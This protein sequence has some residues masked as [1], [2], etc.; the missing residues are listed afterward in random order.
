MRH[1]LEE[2]LGV[3]LLHQ[4]GGRAAHQQRRD[5]DAAGRPRPAS[6]RPRS[7]PGADPAAAFE[8]SRVPVPAPAAVGMQ[9]QVLLQPLVRARPRPVRQIGGDRVGGLRDRAEAFA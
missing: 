3:L 6:A 5:G 8:E 2:F 4:F 7:R 9:P 1:E